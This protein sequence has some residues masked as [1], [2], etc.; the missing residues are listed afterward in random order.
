MGESEQTVE[1]LERQWAKGLCFPITG[2]SEM[3]VGFYLH[4]QCE[5]F[6]GAALHGERE[7]SV[8]QDSKL[9]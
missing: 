2:S 1:D 8:F 5:T 4:K 7:I 6:N 9:L 3:S